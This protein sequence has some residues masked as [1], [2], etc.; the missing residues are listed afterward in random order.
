MERTI[1][2]AASQIN[3]TT[4]DILGNTRLVEQKMSWAQEQQA[5]LLILPELVI[6]GYPP[7]DLVFSPAFIQDN[8]L[9]VEKLSRQ[10]TDCVSLVGFLSPID[11]TQTVDA[12]TRNIT[13]AV[14]LLHQGK[15]KG[16]YHKVL[17]PT[18][19]V[20]DEERYFAA[21]NNSDMVWEIAGVKAGIL[22]CEDLW[23]DEGPASL[24][25]QAGA[26]IIFVINASPYHQEKPKERE[27]LVTRSAKKLGVP[28]VYLN[29]IGGQDELVFDGNSLVA[30]KNGALLYRSPGFQEDNFIIDLKIPSRDIAG[31]FSSISLETNKTKE[32]THLSS[33]PPIEPEDEMYRALVLGVRDY[34]VKNKFSQIV[35]GIS[36]GIDS[37]LTAR[38]SV[39]ALGANAVWG[40]AMP[41]PYSSKG[42][43]EDAKTLASNLGIRF[44]I[45]PITPMYE[46]YSKQF[47]VITLGKTFNVAEE[48]LQA[49]IRG[50]ILMFITNKHGGIVASTGNKSEMSVGYATLY[51]DMC[52]GFAILKDVSKSWV[53]RLTKWR[54]FDNLIPQNT[55]SKP[56]SAELAPEQKDSD[57]L[58]PYDVLDAILEAYIENG[59]S[60]LEI[61]EQGYEQA[62]V[63][64]VLQ[65][66]D[67]NEYKRRQA[68]PGVKV[69]RKAFGRD[70]RLPITNGYSQNT[71][72]SIPLI[73]ET[74]RTT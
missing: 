23:R 19:G 13:N 63:A 27:L 7:E 71:F 24:Q 57:S 47:E 28:I 11:P 56:P 52:G 26:E 14:A 25:V 58:P 2:I 64:K 36:G 39:D 21:G 62:I 74:I 4:G 3:P 17:L 18:Y 53:Y 30:D 55:I 40:I 35:I 73:S 33:R 44:E 45:I 50:A 51:G 65:M 34:C 31:S 38:I 37:A 15:T 8:L 41:G 49:R 20:F 43:I 61:V 10:S 68:A 48:N 29:Q 54:N 12:K 5:D 59:Y 66:V 6:P 72:G 46:A 22:I 32:I 9:A 60:L 70:R 42:S 67:H 16:V 69:T 1:R